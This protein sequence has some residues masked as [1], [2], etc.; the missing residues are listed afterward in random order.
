MSCNRFQFLHRCLSFDNEATRDAPWKTDGFAAFREI[1]MEQCLTCLALGDSLSLDETLYPM[2]T[3]ISFRQYNPNKP[4]KYGLLFKSINAAHFSYTF[5]AAPYCGKPVD[6]DNSPYY[7]QGTEP[8]VR[9]LVQKVEAA[10]T[11]KGRNISFDR[12]YTLIPLVRWL[13]D[14]NIT[15]IGTIQTNRKGIPPGIGWITKQKMELLLD[16]KIKNQQQICHNLSL[17]HPL[18]HQGV[19][20]V[21]LT[22]LVKGIK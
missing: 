11:M 8:V 1:F 19:T 3:Q 15:S 13:Y 7:D 5:V 17:H 2:H 21:F 16:R 10:T 12:L 6:E 14:R 22:L 9:D 4:A 18:P 20:S